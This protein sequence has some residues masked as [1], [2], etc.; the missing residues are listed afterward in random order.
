MQSRI[1][2]VT[3]DRQVVRGLIPYP[4]YGGVRYPQPGGVRTLQTVTR[5][6][7]RAVPSG[8][9][10]TERHGNVKEIKLFYS[11][12]KKYSF[13]FEFDMGAGG[14]PGCRAGGRADGRADWRPARNAKLFS[15]GAGGGRKNLGN[16]PV[17]RG[18]ES[19]FKTRRADPFKPYREITATEHRRPPDKLKRSLNIYIGDVIL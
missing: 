19:V 7:R 6:A 5:S 16:R 14:L 9:F 3:G 13:S 2:E 12:G 15:N 4:V 10:P 11:E 17:S 8:R 18:T 1:R